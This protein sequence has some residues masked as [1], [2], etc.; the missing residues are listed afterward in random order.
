[1]RTILLSNNELNIKIREIDITKSINE[2]IYTLVPIKDVKI[3]SLA[4]IG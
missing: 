1:M 4:I 3:T 2:N